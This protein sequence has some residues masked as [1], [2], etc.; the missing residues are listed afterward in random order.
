[1]KANQVYSLSKESGV[2]VVSGYATQLVYEKDYGN[3]GVFAVVSK[4]LGYY[5]IKIKKSYLIEVY[6]LDSEGCPVLQHTESHANLKA[7][8][9]AWANFQY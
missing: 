6:K 7:L 5:P 2:N 9:K 1:M 4:S 8:K 3:L